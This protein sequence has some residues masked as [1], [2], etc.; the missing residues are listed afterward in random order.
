[1]T[2][3]VS[4]ELNGFGVKVGVEPHLRLLDLLRDVLGETGTK[5]ACGEGECGAC[6]V[7]VDGRVVNSCLFPVGSATRL[8]PPS[9]A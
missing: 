5:E 7:L 4:F 2:I 8:S 1:M 9:K 3:E 6:S